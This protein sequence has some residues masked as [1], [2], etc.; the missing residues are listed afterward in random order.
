ML[1]I[2][3]SEILQVKRKL[4]FHPDNNVSCVNLGSVI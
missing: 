1:S 3:A 2:A 4:I